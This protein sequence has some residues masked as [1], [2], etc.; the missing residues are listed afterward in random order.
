MYV[1]QNYSNHLF[2]KNGEFNYLREKTNDLNLSISCSYND[3]HPIAIKRM[4]MIID[5]I[6]LYHAVP[7]VILST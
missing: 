4:C 2:F 6:Q 3:N 5:F 1:K 7:Y